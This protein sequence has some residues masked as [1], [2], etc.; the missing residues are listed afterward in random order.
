MTDKMLLIEPHQPLKSDVSNY[1]KLF[2]HFFQ[3]LEALW[4]VLLF[5]I[6]IA[7]RA[8]TRYSDARAMPECRMD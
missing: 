1:W 6:P 7:T 2:R 4:G 3:S 8:R 5:K